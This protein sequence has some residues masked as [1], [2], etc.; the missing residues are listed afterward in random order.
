MKVEVDSVFQKIFIEHP[1]GEKEVWEKVHEFM[2]YHI[3]D[4]MLTEKQRIQFID[5]DFYGKISNK[6]Y[7]LAKEKYIKQCEIFRQEPTIK[8]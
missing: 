8:K 2:L 1:N 4:A 5:D 3:L 6:R 7:L